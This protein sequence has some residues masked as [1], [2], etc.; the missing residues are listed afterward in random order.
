MTSP[1]ETSLADKLRSR[2]TSGATTQAAAVASR[3]MEDQRDPDAVILL[4]S[5]IDVDEQARKD[6]G[7]LKPL[8]KS[9]ADHGQKQAILVVQ[10]SAHR[11]KL[12]VGAR[13]FFSIRDELKQDTIIARINRSGVENDPLKWRIGQLHENIQREDY[14]PFELAD[15][16]QSL[17][18]LTG[19][20]HQQ[21][22]DAVGVS[23]GWVSKKLSLLTAPKEIQD[24][25][26]SGEMAETDFYNNK[27]EAAAKVAT[28]K[29]KGDGTATAD[30][31]PKKLSL[32]WADAVEVAQFIASMA[33]GKL[34]ISP[35]PDKEELS[36]FFAEVKRIQ[37][38]KK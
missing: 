20:T 32:S 18:D 25:I 10:T 8:A 4:V 23:R 27:A 7:D 5:Q 13:R 3:M 35:E 9:I 28:A 38:E 22:A 34:V 24:A 12:E 31:T 6:L 14:K 21:L 16:F 19:W 36:A 26:R 30:K 2:E 37:S 17:I 33:K 1:T 15:E 29:N 11:F